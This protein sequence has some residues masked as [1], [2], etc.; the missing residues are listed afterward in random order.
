[1]GWFFFVI[2]QTTTHWEHRAQWIFGARPTHAAQ[3]VEQFCQTMADLKLFEDFEY[4]VFCIS[5]N[6]QAFGER[7]VA[8]DVCVWG[9]SNWT[10]FPDRIFDCHDRM[11]SIK[12]CIVELAHNNFGFC[13]HA[14]FSIQNSTVWRTRARL[15]CTR[16]VL[17]SLN[18]EY[19]LLYYARML[20]KWKPK[21]K[22]Q[23]Y[24]LAK[25]KFQSDVA[26]PFNTNIRRVFCLFYAR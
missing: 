14:A 16:V 13:I 9:C 7:C 19:L 8:Y 18:C 25:L 6:F 24:R 12:W 20:L 5:A 23:E 21:Q 11:S 2:Q 10:D 15:F 26:M 4:I 22:H 1:M 3:Q 17:A